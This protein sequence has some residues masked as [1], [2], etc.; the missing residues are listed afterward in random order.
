MRFAVRYGTVTIGGESGFGRVL[1]TLEAMA[2]LTIT[3]IA[4]ARN[5]QKTAATLRSIRICC[6]LL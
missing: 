3:R 4:V 2:V 1:N 6:P 5:P